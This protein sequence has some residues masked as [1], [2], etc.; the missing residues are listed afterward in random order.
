MAAFMPRSP[1][2][3]RSTLGRFLTERKFARTPALGGALQYPRTGLEPGTLAIV[4]AAVKH[5]G[6][7]WDYTVDDL[8]RDYEAVVTRLKRSRR[9][10][11]NGQDAREGFDTPN[12][13][14]PFFAS[15]EHLY[16]QTATTLG[17]RTGELHLAL[18]SAYEPAFAPEPLDRTALDT[19]AEEMLMHVKA[20]FDLLA[21]RISTLDEVSRTHADA[22][23]SH[24]DDLL[25]RFGRMRT[26]DRAGLRIRIHGDYHLGQ[27]LRTEEDFV[28]LD[29]EGEPARSIEERRAKQSPLKDV[30]GMIRSYS[31][32]AYAALF[33]FTTHTPDDYPRSSPGPT[34]GST[35]SLTLPHCVR[36]DARQTL[37]LRRAVPPGV[38]CSTRS[39]ST[40]RCTSSGTN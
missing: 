15:L 36:D 10:A 1:S 26:L 2:S 38:R 32:A 19:V 12:G 29:F 4:Q 16:L 27:V 6:S 14:P 11:R 17:R 34:P 21:Q 24:R 9:E 35:G 22:I 28:I 31:Y 23:L 7:G 20:G 37:N 33:A 13:T 18:A 3:A 8:R 40:R 25:G 39:F 5:Q 30:A